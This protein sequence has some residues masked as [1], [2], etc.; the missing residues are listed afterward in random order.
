M[1][2]FVLQRTKAALDS[3][4]RDHTTQKSKTVSLWPF[5]ENMPISAVGS[6]LLEG[7]NLSILGGDCYL[8]TNPKWPQWLGLCDAEAR[9]QEAHPA[10][11][12]ECKASILVPSS[13]AFQVHQQ[14]AR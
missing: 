12:G 6:E 9:V 7:T 8:S 5:T 14:Q 2:A 11:P 10:L 13:A 3:C 1:K 4:Y